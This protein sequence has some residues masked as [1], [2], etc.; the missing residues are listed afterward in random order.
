VLDEIKPGATTA[1]A[2][3]KFPDEQ[4]EYWEYYGATDAWQM[5]TNHWGH[6]LGLSQYEVPMTW[7]GASMEHPIT[8]EPGMVMAVET[9]DR[10]G[11]QGVRV[12]EMVV[13]REGGVELLS[14]WPVEEITC[15]E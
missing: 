6:G 8:Y 12:E 7:R 4:A 10:D 14:Q 1:D 15:C 5:T 13:V 9:Q 11:S 3:A 2:A